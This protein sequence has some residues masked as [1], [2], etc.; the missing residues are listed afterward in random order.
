MKRIRVRVR[1]RFNIKL[2]IRGI[3]ETLVGLS[4]AG[5]RGTLL[6]VPPFSSNRLQCLCVSTCFPLWF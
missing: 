3:A 1:V 4:M 5:V 6:R 2:A